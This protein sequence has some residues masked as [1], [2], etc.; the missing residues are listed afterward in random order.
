MSSRRSAGAALDDVAVETH[1]LSVLVSAGLDPMAAVR[2]VDDP[3]PPLR[4][5][6]KCAS[7]L[8]V[9]M[10]LLDA[11]HVATP[12]RDASVRG[13]GVRGTAEH[14]AARAW[15]LIAASWGVAVES[16]APLAATLE[17]AAENLRA[18]AD[19]D[20]QVEIA[21]AGPLATARVVA[22]LP[23]GGLALGFLL[24]A[25]P[26]G[27][28]LGTVP[29]AVSVV[30]GAGALVLG[31]RW[32][33]RLVAEARARDADA[34]VGA[35]L[36]ALALSGGAAPDRALA[37]VAA[38]AQDCRLPSTLDDAHATLDFARRAGVPAAALLRADAARSRRLALADGLR[39]AALLGSR[40]LGPLAV[41]FLPAFVLLGV[42]PL[43]IGILRGV[44]SAF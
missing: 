28:A 39:R 24:G 21:T 18:L 35:E 10:A 42:V 3:S 13:I 41:C 12:D 30:V 11:A 16:G 29:G 7:P 31:R 1:K 36:L 4:A 5:A 37:L 33:R 44:I 17:R 15:S 40:L 23:L 2:A 34:G 9:P 25:D 19:I 6:S 27:V 26:V 20:R 8:E 22:W 14:E 43:M 32:N 38:V